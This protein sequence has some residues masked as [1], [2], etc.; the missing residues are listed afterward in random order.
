[1]GHGLEHDG[2]YL[3][4]PLGEHDCEDVSASRGCVEAVR[5]RWC[6]GMFV[7]RCVGGPE[8][9]EMWTLASFVRI[10]GAASDQ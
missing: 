7:A 8:V 10:S 1:M 3:L 6:F 9:V 2:A 5:R 4:L